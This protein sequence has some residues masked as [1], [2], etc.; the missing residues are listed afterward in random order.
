[1]GDSP[2][3]PSGSGDH[4]TVMTRCP[5][6]LPGAAKELTTHSGSLP[7]AL[8]SSGWGWGAGDRDL[9]CGSFHV[10]TKF[11]FQGNGMCC[12]KEASV[13]GDLRPFPGSRL[14][15]VELMSNSWSEAKRCV[16]GQQWVETYWDTLAGRGAASWNPVLVWR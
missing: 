8:L 1:M 11:N 3:G 15:L 12:K 10:I 13:P 4:W 6:F 2:C 9:S 14:L 16:L 5:L 7:G